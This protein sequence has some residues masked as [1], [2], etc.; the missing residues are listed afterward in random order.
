MPSISDESVKE[1]TGRD[2][3]EWFAL[4]DAEGG[5]D[6]DHKGIVELVEIAGTRGWWAQTVA[7]AY[8]QA[9]GLRE[10]HQASDGWQ[11]SGSRTLNVSV[12]VLFDAWLEE[13]RRSSWLGDVTLV[14]RKA[15]SPKSIRG[16]VDG[17]EGSVDVYFTS[18]GPEKSQVAISHRKLAD[19]EAVQRWKAFWT[20]ALARMKA[21]VEG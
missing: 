21:D 17:G 15:T 14:V 6:R 12:E 13:E 2:W 7:V 3:S 18:K 10:K 5:A 11:A 8:E 1:K 16:A 20:G 19:A 4:L 9:R